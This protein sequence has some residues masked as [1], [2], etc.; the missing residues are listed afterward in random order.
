MLLMLI[1]VLACGIFMQIICKMVVRVSHN[2]HNLFVLL[3]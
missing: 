2:S 1:C 3:C